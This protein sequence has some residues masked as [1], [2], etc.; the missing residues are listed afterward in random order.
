MGRFVASIANLL[1]FRQ[2]YSGAVPYPLSSPLAARLDVLD[3]VGS[4]NTELAARASSPG[5]PDFSVL[6]TE[7][8]TS[9]RG[10]LGRVWV[11]PPGTTIASSVLLRP[12]F[13]IDDYGWIPLLAGLAMSRAVAGLVPAHTVGLKWPNDVQ[14]D[15]LKV[16]GLLAELLPSRD[17]LVMG[18]GVNLTMTREQL[19]T[20]TSTS[21]S[22]NDPVVPAERLADAT[23][24]RYLEGF[25]S[26]LDRLSTAGGD[27]VA[28]GI[29]A[30]VE[31]AC[32]TLGQQVRVE[33]PGGADLVG[34]AVDLDSSGRL[35]VRASA[36]A[37]LVAVAAGD[38]THLR[39]E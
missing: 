6:V 38:V 7:S 39:Y 31:A 18:A 19:P 36:D 37:R 25:R 21:L 24:S 3:E 33:L 22:L 14:I 34:A 20:P 9:G 13:P 5:Y 11:A 10:R 16:S 28:A 32:T 27:A 4:T 30:E 23:L 17:G 15:G 26:L 35:L 2:G 8:Q 1:R 12:T 29:A